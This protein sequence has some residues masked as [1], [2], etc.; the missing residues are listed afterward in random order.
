M[1]MKLHHM[2]GSSNSLTKTILVS[3]R[4]DKKY[5]LEDYLIALTANPFT[6]TG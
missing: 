3:T 1:T 2:V 4:L 6:N 5:S